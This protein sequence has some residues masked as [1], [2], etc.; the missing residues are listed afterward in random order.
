MRN[1]KLGILTVIYLFSET[2]QL[3]VAKL[4]LPPTSSSV[5][6][7]FSEEKFFDDFRVHQRLERLATKCLLPGKRSFFQVN[8]NDISVLHKH[9][10]REMRSKIS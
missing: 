6:T 4:V 3:T 5:Q 8:K 9:V 2:L 7:I 1:D 10:K